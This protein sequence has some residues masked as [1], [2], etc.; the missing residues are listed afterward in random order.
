M[1]TF[2]DRLHSRVEIRKSIGKRGEMRWVNERTSSIT[3]LNRS[4]MIALCPP[5]TD[6]VSKRE[7]IVS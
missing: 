6:Q 4:K 7:S 2:F 1:S 5:G 3:P